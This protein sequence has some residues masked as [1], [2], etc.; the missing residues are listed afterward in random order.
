M[1]GEVFRRVL[2]ARKKSLIAWALSL[3]AL[4][5]MMVAAYPAVRDQDMFSDLMDQYPDFVQQIMGL[6]SG[7]DIASPAGYLNSQVFANMLPLLFLIFLIGF[8]VKETAGEERERTLDLLLA[9]PITRVQVIL[10]KLAALLA[11]G[12]LVGLVSALTL[13]LLGPLA[14]LD[15]GVSGYTGATLAS[16]FV[17]WV[18]GA[19]ALA[20]AAATGSRGVSIGISSGVAVAL[21]IIWGLAPLIDAIAFTN[22]INP[23]YW[24][25][26]GDPILHGVQGANMAVLIGITAA[27][28]TIA[29][30]GFRRRDLGV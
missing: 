12:L 26:A 19:L 8:A 15:L 11:A 5:V 3:V 10:E 29:V 6:G 18:F 9:H 7:L 22:V 4:M 20:L 21:Y 28:S 24:A 13:M 14:Q 25:M 1:P 16:V 23:W 27:L 30:F 2:A 17:A